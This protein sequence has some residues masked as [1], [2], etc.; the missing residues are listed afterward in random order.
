MVK[1]QRENY[2]KKN[3]LFYVNNLFVVEGKIFNNRNLF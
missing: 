2:I 1:F 3:D